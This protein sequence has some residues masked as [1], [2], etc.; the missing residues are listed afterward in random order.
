MLFVE[1]HDEQLRRF[2]ISQIT[3]AANR[4]QMHGTVDSPRLGNAS[5]SLLHNAE[6]RKNSRLVH[7]AG[8]GK[9]SIAPLPVPEVPLRAQQCKP[10][11]ARQP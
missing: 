6:N 7:Y 9:M 2:N 10:F 1:Y 5:S 4:A 8:I 3:I 11:A